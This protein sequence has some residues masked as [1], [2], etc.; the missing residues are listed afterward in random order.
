MKVSSEDM[1]AAVQELANFYWTHFG[2]QPPDP[3]LVALKERLRKFD[4]FERRAREIQK[5]KESD[6]TMTPDYWAIIRDLAGEGEK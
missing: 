1:L 6:W 2:N 5:G 3:R 4:E